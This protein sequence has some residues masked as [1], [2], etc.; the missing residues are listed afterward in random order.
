M[1]GGSGDGYYAKWGGRGKWW[2]NRGV[3]VG[4]HLGI[5]MCLRCAPDITGV[6]TVGPGFT[7]PTCGERWNVSGRG[8]WEY[9]DGA[10]WRTSKFGIGHKDSHLQVIGGSKRNRK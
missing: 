8:H 10:K 9:W 4:T 6:V 7:C 3:E 2:Q 5:R 1:P